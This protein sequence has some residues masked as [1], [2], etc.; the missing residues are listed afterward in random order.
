MKRIYFICLIAGMAISSCSR[1]NDDFDP[2]DIT[3]SLK[4]LSGVWKIESVTRNDVDITNAIDISNFSL[5]LNADGTYTIDNYLPFVVRESGVWTTDNPQYPFKLIFKENGTEQGMD[6]ELKYPIVN[7]ER[8][9]SIT[10]S[11]GCESNHYMY[12]M[13]RTSK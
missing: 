5:N 8:K 12:Q 1:L 6:V 13:K 3:E 10:L 7:G 2:Y 4:D 11:P 9:L